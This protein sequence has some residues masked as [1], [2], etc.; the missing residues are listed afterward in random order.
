[1]VDGA[2][3]EARTESP[4]IKKGAGHSQCSAARETRTNRRF[5]ND[6]QKTGRRFF[7]FLR[8]YNTDDGGWGLWKWELEYWIEVITTR[9]RGI[10]IKAFVISDQLLLRSLPVDAN[11]IVVCPFSNGQSSVNAVFVVFDKHP[12][13]HEE[14]WTATVIPWAKKKKKTTKIVRKMQ[15]ENSAV[16]C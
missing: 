16:T 11:Y 8:F 13:L 3:V 14:N 15:V 1:M 7:V 4:L 5:I 9:L 12:F 2:E 6:R 10:P